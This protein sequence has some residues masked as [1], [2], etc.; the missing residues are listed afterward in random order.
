MVTA[1]DPGVGKP[2]EQP[3]AEIPTT[4]TSASSGGG[5]IEFDHQHDAPPPHPEVKPYADFASDTLFLY[6]GAK[7]A[8]DGL[9]KA[10]E[11][12]A[13]AV[14][15]EGAGLAAANAA[16]KAINYGVQNGWYKM[17]PHKDL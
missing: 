2:L 16:A 7:T 9:K 6:G 15:Y 1:Q 17:N 4:S 8:V 11:K 13:A 14:G 10:I 3:S 12:G 5:G